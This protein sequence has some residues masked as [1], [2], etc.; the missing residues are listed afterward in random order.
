MVMI[1]YRDLTMVFLHRDK[2][3]VRNGCLYNITCDS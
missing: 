1:V 3:G 2:K